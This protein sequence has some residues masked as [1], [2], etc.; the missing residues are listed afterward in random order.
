MQR[1]ISMRTICTMQVWKYSVLVEVQSS[2]EVSHSS[3]LMNVDTHRNFTEIQQI[4]MNLWVFISISSQQDAGNSDLPLKLL[5]SSPRGMSWTSASTWLCGWLWTRV[6]IHLRVVFS[7]LATPIYS[8][9]RG[10]G[11]FLKTR[12][13]AFLLPSRYRALLD[14][15]RSVHYE[16]LPLI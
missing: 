7:L 15:P 4:M 5:F 14:T 10:F 8:K 11:V 12:I 2:S 9:V 3:T 1:C 16:L 6:M 13:K